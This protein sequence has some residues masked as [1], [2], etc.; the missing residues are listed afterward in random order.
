MK[1]IALFLLAFMLVV[2]GFSYT[3]R[4]TVTQK[5]GG[6]VVKMKGAA[7]LSSF[8]EDE[9]VANNNTPPRSIH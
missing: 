3:A 2:V 4:P 8:S 6:A 1:K 7:P 9:T 5:A